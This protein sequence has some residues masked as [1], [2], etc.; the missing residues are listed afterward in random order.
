MHDFLIGRSYTESMI[1]NAR[2]IKPV[3]R[4]FSAK[5][6]TLNISPQQPSMGA[7]KF[8][9]ESPVRKSA[10][11]SSGH[12]RLRS[13][14]PMAQRNHPFGDQYPQ[15]AKEMLNQSACLFVRDVKDER[16]PNF[17]KEEP[18]RKSTRSRESGQNDNDYG[19]GAIFEYFFQNFICF[20]FQGQ[21]SFFRTLKKNTSS[22]RESIRKQESWARLLSRLINIWRSHSAGRSSRFRM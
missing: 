13:P 12:S 7:S 21:N 6:T 20:C 14:P 4:R 18:S 15:T 17:I 16:C 2:P 3:H 8:L 10:P 11:Q 9:Q 5:T 22:V 19:L 1:F